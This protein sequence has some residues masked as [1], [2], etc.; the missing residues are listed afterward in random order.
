[1]TPNNALHCTGISLRSIHASE[2]CPY[3]VNLLPVKA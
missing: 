3:D 2:L 1:M